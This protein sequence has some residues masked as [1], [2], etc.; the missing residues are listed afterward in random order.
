[1]FNTTEYNIIQYKTIIVLVRRSRSFDRAII[2]KCISRNSC[3]PNRKRQYGRIY[4]GS[5]RTHD[6]D[7]CTRPKKPR[8]VGRNHRLALGRGETTTGALVGELWSFVARAEHTAIR[9]KQW[10]REISCE[11]FRVVF[12]V[13]FVFYFVFFNSRKTLSVKRPSFP[14]SPPPFMAPPIKST[15]IHAINTGTHAART[16]KNND[17]VLKVS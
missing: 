7:E 3:L 10:K 5:L 15:I 14:L 13:G 17:S 1:M 6:D 4:S 16:Q 12:S 9:G 11:I 8:H 2:N